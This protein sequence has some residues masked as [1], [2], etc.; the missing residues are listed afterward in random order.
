MNSPT[1]YG[2]RANEDPQQFIDEVYK[3]LFAMGLSLSKKVVLAIYQLKD[4]AQTC[5]VQLKDNRPLRGRPV[6][7]KIFKKEFLGWFFPRETR[8]AK[9]VEFINLRQGVMSFIEYSMKFTKLSKYAPSLVSDPR[10]K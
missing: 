3:V 10:D 7:W 8:E 6:T 9:L 2:S 5:Y 4:V 1:Y